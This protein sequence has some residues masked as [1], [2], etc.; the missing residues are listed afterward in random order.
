MNANV[1]IIKGYMETLYSK[2]FP[3]WIKYL[4]KELFDCNTILDLGCG[5][6]SSI[7]YCDVPFSCGVELFEQYLQKNK[8]KGILS[9]YIHG[10]IRKIEFKPNSFDAVMALD[11]IEHLTIDEGLILIKKMEKWA[12]KKIILLTPNGYLWQDGYDNNPLQEHKSG[13]SVENLEGIGFKVFGIYGLKNLRGYK[14]SLKYRPTLLWA[15]ISDSTQK[16]VYHYPK[17]AA[18]LFGVK[19]IRS[20]RR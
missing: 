6:N 3:S 8:T 1:S 19:E 16:I 7:Q 15:V 4:K 18:L 13:W 14:M 2:L 12:K 5:Y 10:D 17:L 11:V 9:Q 20:N